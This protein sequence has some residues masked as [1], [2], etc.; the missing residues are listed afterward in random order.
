[1]DTDHQA[2]AAWVLSVQRK[3]YQWSKANPDEAWRDL[4]NWVTDLRNLRQAWRRVASNRGKHAAGVDGV[5]VGRILARTG[6]DRFL[7]GLRADLRSGAYR[8]SP[9][10]RRPIPKAGKPGQF[11]ALGIPTVKDRVVQGA[12]KAFLEPIFEAQFWHVS[13]GFRPGRSTHGAVAHILSAI[14][15]R[16]WAED[17]RRHQL[18]YPWVIEGDIK[19]CFDNISHHLL[20]DAIRKRIADRKV[21]GLLRQFLKAGVL[22]EDQFLRT[23][24]GTPQGGIVSP[25]LA[26]IA[27]SAVEARYERWVHFRPPPGDRHGRDAAARAYDA[28]KRDKRAGRPV[29]LPIRYADDFVILVAGEEA[30]AHAERDALAAHLRRCTGLELSAE[31]TRITAARNGFEFLGFHIHLRW[32]RRYGYCPRAEIPKHKTAALRHKV[33]QLTGRDSTPCSL[34]EKLLELNPILRGWANYYR[35]CAGA[36][37]V[38]AS[39]D[40]YV[41]DRLWRW[42]RKKHPKANARALALGRRPSARRPSHHLWRDGAI[43]QHI[44]GWT[45]V[46]RYRLAWMKRPDFAMSSGEPDA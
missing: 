21:V 26:N 8:P 38:F 9:S 16:R 17:G 45:S 34:G 4:W 46:Q 31:K 2:D 28:R 32:D 7:E 6:V 12:I 44:A 39:L 41:S 23:D 3:L 14:L 10:R 30:D 27:L 24:A 25:L 36:H 13:Y 11:R 15:P 40:W 1:M 35:H 37:R 20:L 43:E 18:P 29:F 22:S 19:G 33:K 5:T 42:Q